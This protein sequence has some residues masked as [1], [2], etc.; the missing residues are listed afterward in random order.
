[1]SPQAYIAGSNLIILGG[2]N[3]LIQTITHDDDEKLTTVAIHDVTGKIATA[4]R[5]SLYIYKPFGQ[6]FNAPRVSYLSRHS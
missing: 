3:E 5:T 6:D 1:M 4:T 2:P